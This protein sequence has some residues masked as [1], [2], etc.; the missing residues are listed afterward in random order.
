MKLDRKEWRQ[1]IEK[2]PRVFIFRYTQLINIEKLLSNYG[3]R[4]TEIF[5]FIKQYPD[6]LMAN[7]YDLLRKKLQLL[8]ELKLNK[9][10]IKNLIK[11]YP[12]ILLKSYNSFVNKVFYFNNELRMDIEDIDIYPLIYVFNLERDI[13]PRCELMKKY[14]TWL[15]FSQVFS[16]SMPELAEKLGAK[17]EEISLQGTPLSN[18]RDLLFKYSK[19]HTI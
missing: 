12:F 7:R 6:L 10:T 19:Y 18:E 5:E 2:D 13:K 9:T 11:S 15:P 14:N 4:K 16:L 8:E 1:I 3:I 17:Q